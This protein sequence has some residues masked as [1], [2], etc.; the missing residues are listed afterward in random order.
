MILAATKRRVFTNR[1]AYCWKDRWSW[2]HFQSPWMRCQRELKAT[3]GKLTQ[4]L[5]AQLRLDSEEPECLAHCPL[6]LIVTHQQTPTDQ[7]SQQDI[8]LVFFQRCLSQPGYGEHPN[9]TTR[10]VS[11]PQLMIIGH[12][13]PSPYIRQGY[14][15]AP[16]IGSGGY[17]T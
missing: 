4:H 16:S 3:Y 10:L 9:S 7:E 12:L 8:F 17:R 1:W 11:S 5:C 14:F 15:R 2:I 13:W 6:L